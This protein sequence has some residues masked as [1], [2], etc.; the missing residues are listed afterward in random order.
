MAP[1]T[2]NGPEREMISGMPVDVPLTNQAIAE[3]LARRSDETDGHRQRAY[4]R[5]SAAAFL[6]PEE[7]AEVLAQGRKLTELRYVGD[8]L[9]ARIEGWIT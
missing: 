8:R 9:A 2:R 6:W 3:L 4:R 5:S 7:A 1:V